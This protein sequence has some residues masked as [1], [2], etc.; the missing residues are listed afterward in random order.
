MKVNIDNAK[1]IVDLLNEIYSELE[2][3]KLE[4]L[5]KKVLKVSEEF[6]NFLESLE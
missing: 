2:K 6:A 1:N 3:L 5:K 4:K